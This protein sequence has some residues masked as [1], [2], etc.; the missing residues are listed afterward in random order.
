M[1]RHSGVPVTGSSTTRA[2]R[3]KTSLDK[4]VVDD[5][6]RRAGGVHP[7]VAQRDE[8]VGVAARLVEV[9]EHHHDR[10]AALA[11]EVVEQVEHVD[12]VR[13]VEERRRLVEQEDLGLLRERHRDP[14]ALAL[15][16]GELVER[17]RRVGRSIA[18]G[19]ER[20]LDRGLV[21]ADHWRNS[22][23]CG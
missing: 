14:R 2:S 7:A 4:R 18:G 16:A 5:L 9:V 1:G 12:L 13:E 10:A 15:A 21:A 8:V 3:P 11:H 17:A 6:A 19:G 20:R 23:W 22:R